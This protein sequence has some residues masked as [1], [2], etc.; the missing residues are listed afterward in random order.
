MSS[1]AIELLLAK[2]GNGMI[3]SVA[4]IGK[5]DLL[6]ILALVRA[7]T[8]LVTGRWIVKSFTASRRE[9]KIPNQLVQIGNY[10][11]NTFQ[12]IPARN[13]LRG[14]HSSIREPER[15]STYLRVR[16]VQIVS[17]PWILLMDSGK[18][19]SIHG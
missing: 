18:S 17:G 16:L 10:S 12:R 13:L 14:S 5:E 19:P 15:F 9:I 6:L 7:S 4:S 8:A 2:I 3:R 11:R 1:E